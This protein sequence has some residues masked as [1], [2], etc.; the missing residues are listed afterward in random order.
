VGSR[1]KTKIWSGGLIPQKRGSTS[2]LKTKPSS[3]TL[4]VGAPTFLGGKHIVAGLKADHHIWEQQIRVIATR[5]DR[6]FFG[7]PRA[8][9][10]KLN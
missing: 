2:T 5:L 9:R 10:S 8:L 3:I 6:R 4:N 1:A 7:A